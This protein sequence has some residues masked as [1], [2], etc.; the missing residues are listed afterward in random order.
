MKLKNTLFVLFI[1]FLLQANQLFA[2]NAVTQTKESQAKM[3]P[4]SALQMLKDG[5][6]RFHEGKMLHYD[7]GEQV[8]T[9]SKGQYPYAIVLSCID[10]R[11]S[12]EIIFD[13]GIGDVFNARVAGNIV[14]EDILGSMEY[15]CK[16]AGA[17]LILVI[18][19]SHCGAVKGACDNVKLGNLTALLTKIKPAV[20][21]VKTEPK[22]DRSSKNHEFVEHVSA[23]NVLNTIKDIKSKSSILKEMS[24]K[25]EIMI[26]GAM[27]ELDSG[28]VTFY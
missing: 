22:E 20:D 11:T 25:G 18:G 8:I 12:T 2:Q 23:A 14:D 16:V 1:A 5:N 27:Y 15:S 7:F 9:T 4:Q 26:V 13:Q 28:E 17:K 3:T 19:H 6:K 10:S 21:A 24:D